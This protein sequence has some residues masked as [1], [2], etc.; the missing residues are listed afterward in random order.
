MN[1]AL[2]EKQG[3][4]CLAYIETGNAS[5]AYR[6]AYDA[7]SMKPKTVNRKAK[8]LMDNGKIT[9]RI[10]ELRQPAVELARRYTVEAIETLVSIMRDDEASPAAR[11]SAAC[12][13]LDRGHGKAPATVEG[14]V[15]HDHEHH[16]VHEPLSETARWIRGILGDEKGGG[17]GPG[18]SH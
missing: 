18:K 12:E 2:T 4:F 16:H 8:E 7:E 1:M 5:E 10:A 14:S 11:V 13:I 6:R 9:A 17:H 15:K 3:R